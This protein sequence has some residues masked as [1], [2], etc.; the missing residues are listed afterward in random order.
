MTESFGP[1]AVELKNL[2]KAM[3]PD[4]GVTKGDVVDYYRQVSDLMLPWL[5]D[6]VLTM[7]RFPDGIDREGFFQKN[8][9]DYFP[10]WFTR[11]TV[12]TSGGK[13][14]VPV[15]NNLASLVYLANQGSLTQHVWLS[16]LGRIHYPDQMI[17]DLDPPDSDFEVVR[18]AAFD[19]L[20]IMDL[21]SL[22]AGIKTT[23]SRGL[24]VVIPL[25]RQQDFDTVRA[26]AGD[27]ARLLVAKY[28]DRYTVEQRID[29]RGGKLYLDVQRNAYGQ[30]AVAPFSLRAREGAPVA[31]PIRRRALHN[32]ELHARSYTLN[33]IHRYLGQTGNPWHGLRRHARG[34]SQARKKLDKLLSSEVET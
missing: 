34:L 15:C 26:F 20:E 13:Q 19:C 9:P 27:C 3:Y 17:F 16:R 7:Q 5:E 12:A 29:Q 8:I 21:L 18:R 10:R 11:Q 23:G 31:T 14:Q 25:R 4:C 30:T 24:H 32:P 6:R 33:N 28:P 22:P 2:D 1:Y